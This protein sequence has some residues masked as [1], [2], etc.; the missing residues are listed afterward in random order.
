M[1]D[2]RLGSSVR[3]VEA[4]KGCKQGRDDGDDLAAV[5]D[6][7]G[8]SLEDEEGRF[9]VD[10]AI[11]GLALVMQGKL[12]SKLHSYTSKRARKGGLTQT[13]RRTQPR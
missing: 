9:G 13:S 7:L 8:T 6:V 2:G 4:R 11:A 12:S 5:G 10:A 1:L 3:R